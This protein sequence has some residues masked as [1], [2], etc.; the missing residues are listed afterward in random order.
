[1]KVNR[2]LPT[3]QVTSGNQPNNVRQAIRTLAVGRHR[4]EKKAEKR[5]PRLAALISVISRD[6]SQHD[7]E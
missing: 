7:I 1:M 5:M 2:L 4:S 6:Y 3:T